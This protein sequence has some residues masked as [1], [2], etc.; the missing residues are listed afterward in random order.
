MYRDKKTGAVRNDP[1]RCVGCWS[2]IMVCPFGV[3]VRDEKER[4]VATKCDLCP[5]RDVPICVASCPNEALVY[6]ERKEK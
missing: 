5:D 6:E 3:I 1:D 2:C 4:K